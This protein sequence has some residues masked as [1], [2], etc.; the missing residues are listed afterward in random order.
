MRTLVA[1]LL[2]ASAFTLSA[3]V[4]SAQ[5]EDIDSYITLLRTDLLAQRGVLIVNNMRFTEAE[6]EV[7]WPVYHRYQHELTPIGTDRADLI[8]DYLANVDRM[9]DTKAKELTR[10]V[11]ELEERRLGVMKKYIEEFGKV[12]PAK[13]VAQLFQ[14]ELQMER[15]I[16][17]RISSR[18]P[19]LI[20]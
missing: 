2:V 1:A 20:K 17:V 15:L 11:L 10:K 16:D 8:K 3:P 12:L 18:L 4:A 14:L 7:F 13:R 6:S 5:V 9:D 19:L